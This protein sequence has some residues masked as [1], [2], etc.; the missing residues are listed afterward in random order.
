MHICN[1][2]PD[3]IESGWADLWVTGIH[4]TER[5]TV[6]RTVGV[7][8]GGCPRSRSDPALT[9]AALRNTVTIMITW[10]MSSMTTLRVSS[11]RRKDHLPY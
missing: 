1:K 5:P 9:D 11:C 7:G 3:T 4:L 6:P 8:V 10:N 2:V